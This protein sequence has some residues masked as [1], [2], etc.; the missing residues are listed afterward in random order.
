MQEKMTT[1]GQKKSISTKE[2]FI[3]A[4]DAL[5]LKLELAYHYQFGSVH[6]SEFWKVKSEQAQN[7]MDA[8]PMGRGQRFMDAIKY[9]FRYDNY[10][11]KVA[12]MVPQDHVYI[13][14]GMTGKEWI[15][16]NEKSI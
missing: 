16:L 14:N 13:Q 1:L 9:D 10:V 15:G 8:S 7:I 11:S 12:W 2:D 3:K 6:D 4:I 5:F